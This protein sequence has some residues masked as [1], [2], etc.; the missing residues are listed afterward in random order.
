MMLVLKNELNAKNLKIMYF[1]NF[2]RNN[3]LNIFQAIK[4]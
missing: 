2:I 4:K 3:K 1:T